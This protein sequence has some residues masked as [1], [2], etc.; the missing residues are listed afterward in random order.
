M[1]GT[2]S[3]Q[4]IL[5]VKKKGRIPEGGSDSW[6]GELIYIPPVPPTGL[7]GCNIIDVS[8]SLKF[9][10]EPRG[11]NLWDNDR[12]VEVSFPITIGNIPLIPLRKDLQKLDI[13]TTDS[14]FAPTVNSSNTYPKL[15][16]E[17][18]ELPPPSYVDGVAAYE[19]GRPNQ[20]KSGQDSANTDANWDFNPRYP[21]WPIT[22][23]SP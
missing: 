10:V 8:Y 15:P 7:E 18:A 9:E 5:Q 22:S 23:T 4:R 14:R 1:D 12:G 17:Y 13:N 20:L 19:D 16:V 6:D 11:F 2:K 21:V 3:T